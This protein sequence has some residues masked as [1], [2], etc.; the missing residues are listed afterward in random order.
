MRAA[1][2]SNRFHN[3]DVTLASQYFKANAFR[4]V[5]NQQVKS[6][7]RDVQVSMVSLSRLAGRAGFENRIVHSFG[8][9]L[10]WSSYF[11]V[12]FFGLCREISLESF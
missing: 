9:S 2:S 6:G 10:S 1:R 12:F 3:F 11:L 7:I 4:M 8:R 5:A